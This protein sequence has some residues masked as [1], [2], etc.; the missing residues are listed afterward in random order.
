MTLTAL[1]PQ[2][3]AQVIWQDATPECQVGDIIRKPFAPIARVVGK[4][5]LK[6]G[7][8]CLVVTF[9]SCRDRHTEEWVVGELAAQAVEELVEVE[10]PAASAPAHTVETLKTLTWNQVQKLHTSLGLKATA[11]SR[12]RRDYENRIIA[13]QPPQPQTIAEPEHIATPM[14]CATCPLSEKLNPLACDVERSLGHRIKIENHRHQCGV[15]GNVVQGWWEA[16]TA[17]DFDFYGDPVINCYGEVSRTQGQVEV[18][19]TVKIEVSET[20]VTATDDAPPNRGDNGRGRVTLSLPKPTVTIACIP[21]A[22]KPKADDNFMTAFTKESEDDCKFNDLAYLS[23]LEMEAQ[24]ATEK[25]VIDSEEEA[26]AYTRLQQI[27]RDI[28][29]YNRPESKPQLSPV[30]QQLETQM[31][32]LNKLFKITPFDPSI[33][34]PT[35]D[36][37]LDEQPVANIEPEGTIYW[38]TPLVEGTIVGKK[39]AIRQFYIRN[40]E[41]FIIIKAGF[42]ASETKQPNVRHQQ[43][44][45][46]IEAG[47]NFNP[48]MYKQYACFARET[49]N[50]NGIGRI[51]QGQD[52]RWWAWSIWSQTDTGH[53]FYSKKIAIGYLEKV[54]QE[55]KLGRRGASCAK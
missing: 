35:Y 49:E 17:L 51:K 7:R 6:D 10:A 55:H 44:R 3:P 50:Y 27:E 29:F 33:L 24:L 43:I 4:E 45:A 13:A 41:I 48:R 47:R 20:V 21:H 30:I 37:D 2:A 15:S 34:P 38:R 8:T 36:D 1:K 9:P 23:Q 28:E 26:I 25:T 16:K 18:I 42:T 14:T 54:A 22:T 46:A 19:E 39:G 40:D 52:G 32:E 12:T 5:T 11:A 31:T 53:P